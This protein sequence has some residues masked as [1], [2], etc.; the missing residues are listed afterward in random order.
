MCHLILATI[1]AVG[2]IRSQAD[3]LSLCPDVQSEPLQGGEGRW[4]L[5]YKS[6]QG[7][8]LGCLY[9]DK[10]NS[11]LDAITF[12]ITWQFEDGDSISDNTII[13]KDAD[14]KYYIYGANENGAN[15]RIAKIAIK[16]DGDFRLMWIC[17]DQGNGRTRGDAVVFSKT[18]EYSPDIS[19]KFSNWLTEKGFQFEGFKKSRID[20][21]PA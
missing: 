4:Y 13:K 10:V 5:I 2:V 12:S 3:D 20:G 11:S 14:E 17:H 7:V 18:P 15:N 1:L 21:C 16:S 8:N 6:F 19:E 9:A